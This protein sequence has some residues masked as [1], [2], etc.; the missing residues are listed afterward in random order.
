M[1]AKNCTTCKHLILE[2]DEE[3]CASCFKKAPP[4]LKWKDYMKE[5]KKKSLLEP[6]K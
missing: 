6:N 1:T 4:Y 2:L 3:P 5:E